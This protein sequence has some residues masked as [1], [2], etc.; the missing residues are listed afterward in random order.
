LRTEQVRA[1]EIVD[2][3]DAVYDKFA[4]SRR[5]IPARVREYPPPPEGAYFWS[6]KDFVRWSEKFGRFHA[7][8]IGDDRGHTSF[9]P[10]ANGGKFIVFVPWN[11]E[12]IEV[13]LK[14]AFG[15]TALQ[16]HALEDAILDTTRVLEIPVKFTVE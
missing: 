10:L 7:V 9:S 15:W 1:I 11:K 8:N 5:G 4:M 13:T 16:R 12:R 14:D 2:A 3:V 6:S